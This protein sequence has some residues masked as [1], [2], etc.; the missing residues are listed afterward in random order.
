MN[1][2]LIPVLHKYGEEF[3]T[4]SAEIIV[5]YLQKMFNPLSVVDIGCGIG[6][7]L[8]VFQKSQISDILG[9]DGEHVLYSNKL[10]IP[11]ENFLCKDLQKNNFEDVN[12]TFDLALCLEVA[13]HLEKEH[14]S[15]FIK[16]ICG[17]S[18]IIVFSAA[19][20]GQT[21]EN[22]YNEQYPNYWQDL[23]V[24]NNFVLLD[25]FRSIFWNNLDIEWWYR[26]NLYL[27]VHKDI[28][29]KFEFPRWD[30]HIY[31]IHDLLEMY[32]NHLQ[33]INANTLPPISNLDSYS[34]KTITKYLL[35]KV[36]N[37]IFY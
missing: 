13:E 19:I 29:S 21:G 4:S 30:G 12:R 7:W 32:V 17:L 8:S 3:N 22:H 31:I 23:F 37:K 10:L 25:P 27:A 26:Q 18:Q 28:E 35:K 24:E 36:V 20:P 15:N 16:Q 11:I 2:T 14:A 5:P 9:I 33:S 6:T 34:A 1:P